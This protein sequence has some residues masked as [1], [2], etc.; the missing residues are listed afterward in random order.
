MGQKRVG[1]SFE[2]LGVGVSRPNVI[3][4]HLK[5]TEFWRFCSASHN[6]YNMTIDVLVVTIQYNI[7]DAGKHRLKALCTFNM[8]QKFILT[9]GN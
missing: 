2:D 3:N 7:L 5:W 1:D 6:L 9:A 4:Q 8:F